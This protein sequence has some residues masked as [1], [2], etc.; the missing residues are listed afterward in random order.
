MDYL[1][2]ILQN[3]IL[4]FNSD[5]T[6]EEIGLGKYIEITLFSLWF[7][8]QSNSPPLYTTENRK[9][10]SV[11]EVPIKFQFTINASQV[12]IHC[13]IINR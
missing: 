7:K 5:K 10:I 9:R 12:G 11:F 8:I 6:P 2:H 4:N 13:F 1:I 3:L